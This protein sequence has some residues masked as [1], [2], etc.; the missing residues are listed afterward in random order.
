MSIK[1]LADFFWNWQAKYN[2]WLA[3]EKN[4]EKLK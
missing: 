4:V 2:I 3:V 1:I